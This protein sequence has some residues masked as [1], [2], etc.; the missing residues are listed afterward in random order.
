VGTSESGVARVM[1][2]HLQRHVIDPLVVQNLCNLVETA[3]AR[4]GPHRECERSGGRA[5]ERPEARIAW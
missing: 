5:D 2:D 4:H 3:E 1:R